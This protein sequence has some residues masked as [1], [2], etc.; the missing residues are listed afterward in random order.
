MVLRLAV[1]AS[2][3]AA[4]LSRV[5]FQ[6][7]LARAQEGAVLPVFVPL[8]LSAASIVLVALRWRLLAE[9]LGLPLPPGLAVRALFLAVFGGQLLPSTMG[10][11]VLR[12]WL[13]ARHAAGIGKIVASL[14]ADRL[15]GLLS[16]CLLFLVAATTTSRFAFPYAGV[17]ASIAVL[18][19]GGALLVFMRVVARRINIPEAGLQP[20]AM[21]LAITLGL[22]VHGTTVLAAALV[23]DAYG[24]E[25]SL[26]LW[27][28]II[29]L[30][31]IASAMPIS[32][33]GWGIR[34][35]VV[36]ALAT[37]MGVSAADALLV[38]MTLGVL[39]LIASLPGAL[40]MLQRGRRRLGMISPT[41]QK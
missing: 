13:L 19:S 20:K 18:A 11:D 39:N 1:S 29:P 25:A 35:A 32:I 28:C 22:L 38:S 17:L 34:E 2:I 8:A 37:T 14:M 31:V 10:A 16:A 41:L 7:V 24:V 5:S 33:N 40:L 26:E 6:D 4:L 9:W 12:G 3:L 23:A 30:S 15:V 36:V 27:L 21:L